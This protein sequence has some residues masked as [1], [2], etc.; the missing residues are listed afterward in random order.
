MKTTKRNKLFLMGMLAAVLAF[1]LVVAGCDDGSGSGGGG[2]NL[3]VKTIRWQPDSNGYTQFY[4]NDTQYYDHYFTASAE[5]SGDTYEAE[6]KKLSGNTTYG[7][8]MLFCYDSS[9]PDKLSYYRLLIT[10]RGSYQIHKRVAGAWAADPIKAWTASTAITA[11]YNQANKLRVVKAGN[12][13]TVYINNQQVH[14]FTDSDI[15]GTKI[16]AYV[17]V[18]KS[19]EESFPNTPV[20][21]RFKVLQ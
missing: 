7:Y 2:G 4:T 3:P 18:G 21:V 20:D 16:G 15:T 5:H 6:V 17:S 9:N 11:G 10:T 8:G 13:F 19:D 1:G 14:T 12:S